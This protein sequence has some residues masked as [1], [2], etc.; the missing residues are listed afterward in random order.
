MAQTKIPKAQLD[1]TIYVSGGADVAITDGGTGAS[2]LP[3]GILKGAGTG[4]ITAA[5]SGTD[6]APATSGSAILKGDGAGG[7]ASASAGSD[8]VAPPGAFQSWTPTFG[9]WTVGTGGLAG[10]TAR[11]SQVGKLTFF[12]IIST[13][14]TS[15]AS[16]SGNV[17]F[18]LPFTARSGSVGQMLGIASLT[19]GGIN[20]SGVAV[21]FNST[22]VSVQVSLVNS[23]YA[24]S[25]SLGASVP[26]TWAAGDSFSLA[27][28]WYEA[29]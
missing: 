14:G 2:T 6:Y 7:F 11:Y 4:A 17:T 15:G 19:S 26:N 28:K 5:T 16:V 18:T 27:S 3:T 21:I 22:S 13:L 20:Y 12:Y 23:T 29:A 25:T 24:N 8:Y 1:S 10:T 9:N